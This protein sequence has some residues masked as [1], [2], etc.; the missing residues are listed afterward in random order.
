MRAI[1]YLVVY[2]L[3]FVSPMLLISYL[4]FRGMSPGKA[5]EIRQRRLRFLHLVAGIVL[6]IMGLAIIRGWL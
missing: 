1:W 2:N 3:V 5:E 4:V 6:L